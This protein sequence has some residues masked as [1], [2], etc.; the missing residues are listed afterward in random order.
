MSVP[1][2][3]A[4]ITGIALAA[5]PAYHLWSPGRMSRG[6][7]NGPKKVASR[8]RGRR[9]TAIDRYRVIFENTR[10]VIACVDTWGRM[11]DVNPAVVDLL[12]YQPEEL[13]GKHFTRL[14][15]LQLSDIP[16]MVNQFRCAIVAGKP[17]EILEFELRHK[18]G[19]LVPVEVST[20]FVKRNGRVCEVVNVFRDMR[21]RKAAMAELAAA[22]QA[23]ERANQSKS[24]FLANV[25][26]EI[27]TPLTSILGLADIILET[28]FQEDMVESAKVIKQ[29]GG[30]AL[31]VIND[32]LDL[33]RIEQGK[34]RLEFADCPVRGTIEE[35]IAALQVSADVKKLSLSLEIASEVPAYFTSDPIRLRQI[36]TNLIGNA[37]KF[38]DEGGIRVVVRPHSLDGPFGICCEIIDTG[39][40][41][42]PEQ[43]G[44]LF[45]PFVQVESSD[46]HPSGSGLGLAISHRLATA[47]GGTITA[48]S[49][50]GRGS[51]FAL[52]LGSRPP[53]H[54]A[55]VA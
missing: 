32:L 10:D 11:R 43:M 27:R 22:K 28:P 41:I 6:N 13:L 5:I 1:T 52:I 51:T 46:C 21:E 29:S 50:P 14:R 4:V 54:Q 9:S 39:V 33:S 30:H 3:I 44:S 38:T 2:A 17:T 7:S 16:R 35:V 8:R 12:G 36:L 55:A 42:S 31:N 24:E 25:S 53:S 37:I 47:L 40:G 26:H 19:T 34:C 20:R 49:Q 18:D 48:T 45:Q 23:A 15:L